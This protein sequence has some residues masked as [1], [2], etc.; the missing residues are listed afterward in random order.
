M[1]RRFLPLYGTPCADC[2]Q[3]AAYWD[4]VTGN[5]IHAA[6]NDPDIVF[7]RD[8]CSYC[9]QGHSDCECKPCGKGVSDAP[10]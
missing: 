5:T 8:R 7:D 1:T 6:L 10:N 9:G 3:P 4:S 2:G